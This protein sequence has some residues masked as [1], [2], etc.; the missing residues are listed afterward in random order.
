VRAADAVREAAVRQGVRV[1]SAWALPTLGMMPAG[2]DPW[3]GRRA[4]AAMA[5]LPAAETRKGGVPLPAG[6]F[7]WNGFVDDGSTYLRA[8]VN[9]FDGAIEWKERVRKGREVPEAI[10]L[11]D[12]PDVRTYLWFARF[13][14][15]FAYT[16]DGKTVVTFSDLRF[17]GG[18]TR[19]PFVLRVIETPGL[20]PRANWGS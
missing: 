19:R 17:G 9:P 18:T 12:L 7:A 15:V 13:P 14:T 5:G 2:M 8:E 16:A 3:I 6:P 11:K 1:V 10:A 4:E 20:P